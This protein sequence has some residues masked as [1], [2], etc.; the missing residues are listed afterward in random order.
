MHCH[1]QVTWYFLQERKGHSE[2]KARN[3]RGRAKSHGKLLTRSR[4]RQP[5]QGHS[6]AQ[7]SERTETCAQPEFRIAKNSGACLPC[8]P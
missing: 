3:P 5:I 6:L 7:E 8:V 4:N 1:T 2:R